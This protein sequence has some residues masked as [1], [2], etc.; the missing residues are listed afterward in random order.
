MNILV[1]GGTGFIGRNLCISLARSNISVTTFSRS[2]GISGI[3]H[4]QGD[5]GS[6]SSV[7]DALRQDFSHVV[8]LASTTIPQ[9]SNLNPYYDVS[10]NLLGML[11]LLES[12]HRH[13][14]TR[15]IHASSGGTVY[16]LTNEK[17]VN[18]DHPTN[19]IC[20]YGIV[21][22]AIEKYLA[23][24]QRERGLNG[25]SLR[26]ANPYGPY[27]NIN[28]PQGAVAIFTQKILSKSPIHLWG[29][30][31][32]TRDYIYIDDVSEAIVVALQN[33]VTGVFNIGT[34]AGI[35]LIKV[36]QEIEAVVR[37]KAE[38]N[39]LPS[40]SVDVPHIV[41]DSSKAERMLGWKAT[42]N[43]STGLSS[44]VE[45]INSTNK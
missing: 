43:F 12:C 42:T 37:Q 39:Y 40:R 18:E 14:I 31:A 19:P 32:V 11:N 1:V 7:D 33:D 22:L 15:I 8:C 4:I 45:W 29:L 10:T 21:K 41:L 26:I 3:P 34:G 2:S 24:Y 35:T 28:G 25:I 9:S 13:R 23:L 16:G 36:I 44:T 17:S 5:L 38:I 6:A 20:S 30:A 27:Q